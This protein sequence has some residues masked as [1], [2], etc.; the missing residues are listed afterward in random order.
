MSGS[1]TYTDPLPMHRGEDGVYVFDAGEAERSV[2]FFN[3]RLWIPE[4]DRAG[5]RYTA[6]P[7]QEKLIRALYGWRLI[8]PAISL[9]GQPTQ[10]A[11]SRHR[12]RKGMLFIPRGNLK[13]MFG[14]GVALK[15]LRANGR[16][17]PKVVGAGTD[18]KNAGIVFGYAAY[19]C[20]RDRA[21]LRDLEV[22]D[23]AKRIRFRNGRAGD[24]VV[25]SA[26]ATHSHGG[27]PT[28]IV[29]DD[30][31]AQ[32]SRELINVLRTSQI[33]LTDSLFLML[34]TA[35]FD[36]ASLGFE[37][38]ELAKSIAAEPELDDQYL[39]CMF[40]ADPDDD[41]EDPAVQRKANPAIGVS[42]EE[43]E[44]RKAVT[45]AMRK[46]S[47]MNEV[48]TLN[49][50]IWVD[51]KVASWIPAEMW[52]ATAGMVPVDML[53]GLVCHAGVVATSSTDIASVAYVFAPM[54]G[55]A[56]ASYRVVVDSFVPR[57]SIKRLE[58][59]S[60]I[61]FGQFVDEGWLT[62]T[63]GDVIDEVAI[64]ES[65]KRRKASGWKI[66]QVVANPRNSRGLIRALALA[67]FNVEEETP[68]FGTMSPSMKEL[69]K[70]VTA[71]RFQHSGNRLLAWQMR[72]LRNRKNT[73]GDLA[74]DIEH[75]PGSVAG[76]IATLFALGRFLVE[77]DGTRRWGL[78]E[79]RPA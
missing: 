71:K 75:S 74:P 40:Y 45:E 59:L 52:R 18:R 1:W 30:T 34:M 51:A 50:N 61:K 56:T 43:S 21:F 6:P 42:I 5:Q 8:T 33:T 13:S 27:H 57:N 4:G 60:K 28:D 22:L 44:I 54:A 29:V 20:R 37:E 23:G 58:E 26:D 19:S 35:G 53:A 11:R 7:Y 69:E 67:R 36:V 10:P 2:Q 3:R 14:E 63:D 15:A 39:P 49:F 76:G 16:P 55:D 79:S 78:A 77:G 32:P 73:D 72:N 68:G 12:Y 48:L 47:Q 24:Y 38:C 31:Q 62:V 65:I 9:P 46:P 66:G 41:I 70:L 17:V 25:I 64:L